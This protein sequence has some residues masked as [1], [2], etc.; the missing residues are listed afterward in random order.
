MAPASSRVSFP[1]PPNE[2][3]EFYGKYRWGLVPFLPFGRVLRALGDLLDEDTGA[4]PEWCRKEWSANVFLFIASAADIVDEFLARG[5]MDYSKVAD[6]LPLLRS[7]VRWVR[8]LS[9]IYRK[10]VGA[11]RDRNLRT[12]RLRWGELAISASI[13]LVG[14]NALDGERRE[15]VKVDL[16]TLCN[17][18]FPGDLLTK[19]IRIPAAFRSQ[20]L[21]HHDIAFL[22][23]RFAE[24]DGSAPHRKTLVI[25]L[26]T[27]GS[28][29]APL[30]CA[31]LR[32]R[33]LEN[34]TYV[35][36]RPKGYLPPH[37][38][39]MIG[40]YARGGARFI[41]TDEPPSTGKSILR[42]I[43]EL[44]S[45]GVPLE[46]ITVLVPTHQSNKD[47]KKH[48][49]Q[50][51]HGEVRIVTMDP[52]E[53]YKSRLLERSAF[54]RTIRDYLGNL[55][56]DVTS[57]A[58]DGYAGEMNRKIE[59]SYGKG[60]H[61]RLKKVY[62]VV[63]KDGGGGADRRYVIG[64]SVGWGWFGYHS[65][66]LSY[67]LQEY[68]P[69]I[70]GLRDGVL[71][72]EWIREDRSGPPDQSDRAATVGDYIAERAVKFK[73]DDTLDDMHK[74]REGG[75]QPIANIL[76]EVFG[77]KL[78]KLKKGWAR[79]ILRD[80]PFPPPCFIDGRMGRG[81]WLVSGNGFLKVDFE[82][83]GFSKTAS[84]N[85]VD[86]AYDLAQAMFEFGLGYEAVS[87]Y[88]ERTGDHRVEDRLFFFGLL[89]GTEAL[90][91]A[92]ATLSE[93]SGAHHYEHF[94]RRYQDA[95][96]FL[97]LGAM[98][99]ASARCSGSLHP[100]WRDSLLI[101]DIDDVFEKNLFGFPMT[102][103]Y[104]IKA[105]SLL[106]M[107]GL[108]CAVNTA[109][110]VDEVKE[111]CRH[112]G[113]AGGG[114]EYGSVFWDNVLQKEQ[115][116]IAGEEMEELERVR[117]I[118]SSIPGTFTNPNYRFSIR[119]YQYSKER[120]VPVPEAVVGHVFGKLGIRRLRAHRTYIDTAILAESANKGNIVAKIRA[121][122]GMNKGRIGA[123]GDSSPDMP[124]LKMADRGY[125]V[126]N[127]NV[128]MKR[129]ARNHNIHVLSY[130]YQKGLYHAVVDF[131]HGGDGGRCALCKECERSFRRE[132]DPFMKIF[133]TA[134]MSALQRWA[135]VLDR[136][137]LEF[138]TE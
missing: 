24:G 95:W 114:A 118:L 113:F 11:V 30:I 5:V 58:E 106:G 51:K 94:N 85:I 57:V 13:P 86:P 4:L 127:A 90:K 3:K 54:E 6:Y 69:R 82:H 37:E 47:W 129:E 77:G 125:V 111:Y 109:R 93:I 33:G 126:D 15:Q 72:Y 91:E 9:L 28:Y 19:R 122:K 70:Y 110:Y 78:S 133:K 107:H 68:I 130:P 135:R 39:R 36:I 43:G 46:D 116:L 87:K 49:L 64:K 96:N 55:N 79:S 44:R 76:C 71:Y 29:F 1:L 38:E 60:Y 134:D 10:A 92:L 124:M 52:S 100:E 137:I 67:H 21:S 59:S 61:V 121:I 34:A 128:D 98:R 35:T 97:V 123:I 48:I 26:R 22:S 115:V 104:G 25:G 50:S 74:Y 18:S 108:S 88:M 84:H 42:T 102:T 2:E 119:A 65:A 41:V 31:D 105:I 83:H 99:H 62:E 27:A 40:E 12:W 132:D 63:A 75:L 16:E 80:L 7:P 45:N 20:D 8:D 66:I 23:R 103:A 101:M 17:H 14:N 138:M 32:E 73:L 81:E 112:Y 53:L 131:I 56:F 89:V 136:H 120:T 117:E